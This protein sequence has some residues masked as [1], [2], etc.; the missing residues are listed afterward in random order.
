M[1]FA[2]DDVK[3]N[4]NIYTHR[5]HAISE[6]IK[7][8]S[9]SINSSALHFDMSNKTGSIHWPMRA[10]KGVGDKAAAAIEKVQPF[11]SLEDLME[12]VEKRVVNK[13]V[14]VK[15]ISAGA[16]RKFGRPSDVMKR[17]FELKKEDYP[18]ALSGID[19]I[20]WYRLRDQSLGFVSRSYKDILKDKFSKHV[21]SYEEFLKLRR[22]GRACIG[23]IVSKFHEHKARN[24]KMCF[25]NVEDQT[26]SYEIVVFASVYEHIKDKPEVG[27]IVEVRGRKGVSQRGD[28]QMVLGNPSDD[29]IFIIS[30]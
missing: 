11:S 6:G 15:L 7:I 1:E 26:D 2:A 25:M 4:E 8:L 21:M 20:G 30:K 24:G 13:R 3:K 10:V 16:L 18:E 14:M 23:G 19:R 9:P 29:K 22:E 27:N 12:R 28:I 5:L 17:Y